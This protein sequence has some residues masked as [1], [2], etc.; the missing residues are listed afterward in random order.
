VVFQGGFRLHGGQ[1]AVA[2]DDPSPLSAHVFSHRQVVPTRHPLPLALSPAIP[3]HGCT[4][5]SS[6]GGTGEVRP[7]HPLTGLGRENRV[8]IIPTLPFLLRCNSGHHGV[9]A[10]NSMGAELRTSSSPSPPPC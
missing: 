3:I 2:A 1:R 9:V 6:G 10:I 7:S 4:T 8:A 5:L